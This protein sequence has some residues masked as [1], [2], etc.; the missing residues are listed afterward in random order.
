MKKVVFLHG[1][2]IVLNNAWWLAA[3][4]TISQSEE[5]PASMRVRGAQWL[6]VLIALLLWIM[7]ISSSSTVD[8]KTLILCSRGFNCSSKFLFS[9]L[10]FCVPYILF[11]LFQS[12]R[13]PISYLTTMSTFRRVS[14][15]SFSYVFIYFYYICTFSSYNINI[16]KIFV[17]SFLKICNFWIKMFFFN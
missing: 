2:C 14:H 3:A 6:K 10:F 8:L 11:G 13:S 5:A 17:L 16:L 4:W 15:I 7:L 9:P 12:G 1:G